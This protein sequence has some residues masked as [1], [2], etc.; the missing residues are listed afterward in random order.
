MQITRIKPGGWI[1]ILI[2][3]AAIFFGVR[4]CHNVM[5]SRQSAGGNGDMSASSSGGSTSAQAANGDILVSTTGTKQ[6]W[7]QA[8]I[9]KFNQQSAAGK[10]TLQLAESRDAMH[11][12]L[13]GKMQPVL[14]S[15]SSPVWVY[16]LANVWPGAHN[17]AQVVDVN[18][19]QNYRALFKSPLVFVT[20]KEKVGFLKPI[21]SG[22]APWE[23]IRQLSLGQRK[24]PWGAFHF[25]YADPLNASSGMLT[26]SLIITSYVQAH[27]QGDPVAAASSSQFATYLSQINRAF[28]RDP[29]ATGSSDLEK[30][31]TSS[32]H[33]RD[34]ITAY[35]S[36]A[37]AAV[38]KNSELA[39]IYP[40]P[41]ANADQ[42]IYQLSG[43]WVT[44][45][46]K[47]TASAFLDFLSKPESLDDGVQY[48]FRPAQNGAQTLAAR[49]SPAVRAQY[50][51]SYTSIDLPPYDA[52]NEAAAQWRTE[53][54]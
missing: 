19:S 20:T 9:D 29:A 10:V 16:Q 22:P 6:K 25:A 39:I 44:A 51:S 4:S 5:A 47:T 36:A 48:Y 27:G 21:L 52:L 40:S 7:M 30:A 14:W 42:T 26:M 37:L 49:L 23:A 1:I 34:F 35:E 17:G 33:S 41:T 2:V 24:A 46:Q 3:L 32:P 31:Y 38:E 15:P 53:M 28:V 12:I 11:G 50:Q 45:S 13:D 18:G 43:P 8:E 54:K